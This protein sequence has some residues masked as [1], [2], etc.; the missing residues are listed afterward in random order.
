MKYGPHL[1]PAAWRALTSQG[2]ED[3]EKKVEKMEEAERQFLVEDDIRLIKLL[4]YGFVGLILTTVCI[5]IIAAGIW[6]TAVQQG[7]LP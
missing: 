4:V 2:L 6:F 5:G 3:L 7:P 1:P